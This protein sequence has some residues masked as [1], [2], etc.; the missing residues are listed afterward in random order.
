MYYVVDLRLR[1]NFRRCLAVAST[2]NLDM[3]ETRRKE[4]GKQQAAWNLLTT[5]Q[6]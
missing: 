5:G 2:T 4:I 1:R 6:N 3:L